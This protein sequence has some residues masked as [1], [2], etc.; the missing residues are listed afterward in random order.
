MEEKNESRIAHTS[1]N[2]LFSIILYVVRVLLGFVSR[3]VF[4]Y[5][6]Y[7]EYLGLNSLFSNILTLLSLAEMG[8][9]N[10]IIFSMYKPIA[11]KDDEKV[12][13]LLSLYKKF[14]VIVAA[15]IA[16]VGGALTPFITH[17]VNDA[18]NVAV[19]IYIVYLI[20]LANTVCSYFLSYRRALLITNQRQDI[21]SKISIISI[22]GVLFIYAFGLGGIAPITSKLIK[23]S[24]TGQQQ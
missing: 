17:L 11:E 10:A 1:K 15:I 7:K 6:L 19:N 20:F 8:F 13:Q 16:V 22:R 12:K 23:F 9:G 24:T 5:Y 21:E 14:Y 2:M 3:T 4:I 18:P